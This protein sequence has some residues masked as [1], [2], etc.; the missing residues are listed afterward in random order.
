L[1]QTETVLFGVSSDT[2]TTTVQTTTDSSATVEWTYANEVTSVK[3]QINTLG[4]GQWF[5]LGLSHDQNMVR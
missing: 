1:N 4:A 3:M 2:S 5:A